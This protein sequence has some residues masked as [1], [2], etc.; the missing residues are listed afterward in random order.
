MMPC[1]KDISGAGPLTPPRV[2][3]IV[4]KY[5]LT[6][7]LANQYFDIIELYLCLILLNTSF[8]FVLDIKS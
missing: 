6:S 1:P 2:G 3:T 8:L 7:K 4:T 5:L